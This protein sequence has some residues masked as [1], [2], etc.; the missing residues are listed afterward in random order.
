MA[1]A[2][3]DNSSDLDLQAQGLL[4]STLETESD[5][6]ATSTPKSR[7]DSESF[8]K[9][10]PVFHH[11]T[12][13][14]DMEPEGNCRFQCKYCSVKISGNMRVTSNFLRHLRVSLYF[15]NALIFNLKIIRLEAG[16]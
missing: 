15:I 11:F 13:P 6:Q 9:V 1:T 7:N 10:A 8:D 3:G 5:T 14:N 16:M 4:S 2:E 12:I